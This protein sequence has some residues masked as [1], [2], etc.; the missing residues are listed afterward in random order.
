MPDPL[1]TLRITIDS[2]LGTGVFE[3]YST[4]VA[5]SLRTG[6]VVGGRGSTVNA[7]LGQL[8]G[9]GEDSKRKGVYLDAGGGALTWNIQFRQWEGASDDQNNALQ[10][11]DDPDP[12]VHTKTSA[13]GADA[14]SKLE[15]LVFWLEQSTIDS[16]NPATLEY[17]QHY[18][19]GV[20]SAKDIVF[21]EPQIRDVAED[22]TWISGDFTL[23]SAADLSQIQDAALRLTT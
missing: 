8:A 4:T 13:T 10:W 14:L 1:D 3:M 21:E 18:P 15:C 16:D 20:Y 2:E 23:V 17:G 22:G 7:V 12:G 9:D 5:P 11:G 6:Y 19:D